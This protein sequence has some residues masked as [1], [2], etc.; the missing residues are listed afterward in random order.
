MD[1]AIFLFSKASRHALGTTQPH[2]KWES[3]VTSLGVRRLW[4]EAEHSHLASRLRMNRTI[5]TSVPLHDFMA[6]TET[7]VPLPITWPIF[8][9]A[10][11]SNRKHGSSLMSEAS[12]W[13]YQEHMDTFNAHNIKCPLSLFLFNTQKC[14]LLK[15]LTCRFLIEQLT[16]YICHEIFKLQADAN[17]AFSESSVY[18]RSH[19]I[20]NVG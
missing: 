3:G 16:T 1:Q 17:A 9:A 7:I 2:I 5:H 12:P 6:C 18:Y 15:C 20:R 10:V 13:P 19:K 4:C 11:R 8:T 14:S